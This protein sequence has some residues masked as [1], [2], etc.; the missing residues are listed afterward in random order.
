MKRICLFFCLSAILRFFLFPCVSMQAQRVWKVKEGPFVE[1]DTTFLRKIF[2]KGPNPNENYIHSL[3]IEKDRE[4]AQYYSFLWSGYNADFEVPELLLSA[5]IISRKH[6][7]LPAGLSNILNGI[8]LPLYKYHGKY[9]LY[10]LCEGNEWKQIAQPFF[11]SKEPGGPL[12]YGITRLEQTSD[13]SY[14]LQVDNCLENMDYY[15]RTIDIHVIDKEKGI[16][17]WKF[18]TKSGEISYALYVE[19][20][21]AEAFDLIAWKVIE[22]EDEFDKFEAIDYP[23][24][25]RQKKLF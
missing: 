15:I 13:S 8:Y 4:S 22:L 6:G 9:Y 21:K 1:N 2:Y 17:V 12:L 16:Y 14:R 23:Q 11:I 20:S 24:I 3:Y 25:I 5:D 7:P 10:T 19:K 18:Q